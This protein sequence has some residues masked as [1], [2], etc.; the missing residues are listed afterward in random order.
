M[1]QWWRGRNGDSCGFSIANPIRVAPV[2]NGTER[3]DGVLT[4][5]MAKSG[6]LRKA[7]RPDKE[8]RNGVL[9]Y[10]D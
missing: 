7:L 2:E 6:W 8:L 5:N 10:K 3:K 1:K 4:P 9:I